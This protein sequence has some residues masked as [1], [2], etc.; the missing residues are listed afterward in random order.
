MGTFCTTTSIETMWVG[1]SFADLTT[2]A[3]EFIGDAEDE[4]RAALSDRY[5]VSADYFQTSTATPPLLEKLC[6]WKAIGYLY[7]N[8]SRGGKDAFK[9]ADW[10]LNRCDKA[11]KKIMDRDMNLV[12]TAGSAISDQTGE[13]QVKS[14]TEDYAN[15]FNED[16]ALNW[17][18]DSDKLNAIDSERS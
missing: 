18:V 10:Y 5:D 14:S 7:G 17:G 4:L 3:Q 11:I 6:K 16:D 9:R 15:T 2:L 8:T 1:S 12:D 13:L